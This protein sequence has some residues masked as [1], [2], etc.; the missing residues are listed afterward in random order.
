VV[1]RDPTAAGYSIENHL[2]SALAALEAHVSS[3]A[4]RTADKRAKPV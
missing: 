4:K 1:R 2:L 3:F